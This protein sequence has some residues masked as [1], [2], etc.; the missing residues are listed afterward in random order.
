[1]DAEITRDNEVQSTI[2][3]E[4]NRLHIRAS[5][6]AANSLVARTKR[7]GNIR[8]LYD[9]QVSLEAAMNAQTAAKTAYGITQS[10]S[11]S[12]YG[13]AQSSWSTYRARVEAQKLV[14]ESDS[15]SVW[16]AEN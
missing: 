13:D 4:I 8:L 9:L 12:N 7:D 6:S 15:R 1:L 3:A 10:Q 5:S 11:S 16:S 2:E 14:V